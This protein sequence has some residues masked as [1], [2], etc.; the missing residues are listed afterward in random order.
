MERSGTLDKIKIIL[1]QWA[2]MKKIIIGL[3]HSM[4]MST[5]PEEICDIHS[6]LLWG[7]GWVWCCSEPFCS[8][9]LMQYVAYHTQ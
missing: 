6:V 8:Y 7:L 1:P 2:C 4:V 5:H 9:F 3:Y